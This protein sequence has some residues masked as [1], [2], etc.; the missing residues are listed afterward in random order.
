MKRRGWLIF[1][2]VQ[3]VGEVCAWTAG[4]FLSALGPALWVIGSVLLLPGDLTGAFIVEKLLWKTRLTTTELT[5][6]QVPVGLAINAVVWLLCA[7]LLNLIVRR[8]S[9]QA[10]PPAHPDRSRT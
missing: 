10:V 9:S 3:A 1:L 2:A 6:L 7:K 5:V 4:H 8:R